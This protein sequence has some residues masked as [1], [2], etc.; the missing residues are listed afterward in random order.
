[1]YQRKKKRKSYIIISWYTKNR[2][3]GT[4][5]EPTFETTTLLKR[6]YTV[7]FINLLIDKVEKKMCRP[8]GFVYL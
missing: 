3:K 1:M 6:T 2:D 4:G 7:L 5:L 8:K